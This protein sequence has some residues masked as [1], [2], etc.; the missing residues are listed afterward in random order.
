MQETGSSVGLTEMGVKTSCP[1]YSKGTSF[2]LFS[3]FPHIFLGSEGEEDPKTL[4]RLKK[5][6]GRKP[7][8]T[9]QPRA[10][11]FSSPEAEWTPEL[12]S[13]TVFRTHLTCAFSVAFDVRPSSG[14]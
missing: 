10:A 7:E 11:L 5:E 8:P 2:P 14:L 1:S 9:A 4:S 3:L 6:G 13:T 12:L